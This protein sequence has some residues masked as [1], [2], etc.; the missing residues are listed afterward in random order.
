MNSIS[1]PIFGQGSQPAEEDGVE[2]DYLQMPQ[3]MATYPHAAGFDGF[4][5][6]RIW[7][8]QKAFCSNWNRIWR[9]YP[10][11][12]RAYRF[13]ATG[14]RSI[15]SLLMNCSAKAK[16]VLFAPANSSFRIQESVL[17]GVWRLQQLNARQQI[18]S[19]V[20]EVGIIPQHLLAI[21]V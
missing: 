5:R 9:R 11:V 20:L 15:G 6:R 16:S 18:V 12:S 2:L 10:S 21:G 19:D 3:E 4:K 13:D 17:A 1:L 7:R 8:R 14:C